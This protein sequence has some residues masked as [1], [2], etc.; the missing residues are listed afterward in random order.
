MRRILS[1]LIL[2]MLTFTLTA[3]AE[4]AAPNPTGEWR[5]SDGET[6]CAMLLTINP[7]GTFWQISEGRTIT[8]TWSLTDASLTLTTAPDFLSG[9]TVDP[10]TAV[11]DFDEANAV[12]T[13][14]GGLH[15]TRNDAA[16]ASGY[17]GCSD[18]GQY[19]SLHLLPIGYFTLE[20]CAFPTDMFSLDDGETLSGHW[21]Q[22][23]HIITL[24][25]DDGSVRTAMLIL[26]LVV[27]ADGQLLILDGETYRE[28]YAE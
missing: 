19:A 13:I 20:R 25:S 22:E 24:H 14:P 9:V 15:L 8:G 17:W 28:P 16:T 3:T 21:T 12:I 2:L 5:T 27:G 6:L 1:L 7:D 26:N 23:G 10:M 4:T 18:G 11:Y